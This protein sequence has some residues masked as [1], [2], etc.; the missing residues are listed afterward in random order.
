MEEVDHWK[1][2][3]KGYI[4]SPGSSL[5]SLFSWIPW[6]EHFILYH[7]VSSLEAANHELCGQKYFS[8]FIEYSVL[9]LGKRT[10]VTHLKKEDSV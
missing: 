9:M 4:S 5:L 8:S 2:D 7:P 6:V 3:L 1:C 10:E